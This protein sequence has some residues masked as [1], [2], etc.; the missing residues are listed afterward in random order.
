MAEYC[1]GC[2]MPYASPEVFDRPID[3]GKYGHKVDVYSFGVL[4]MELLFDSL[5]ISMRRSDDNHRKLRKALEDRTYT[6]FILANVERLYYYFNR[7]VA[8]V[9]CYVAL[10]CLDPDP[11]Q[12]PCIDWVLVILRRMHGYIH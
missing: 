4:M 8:E 7:P 2:T 5:P 3:Y 1:P 12:R 9:L 10:R 6:Q 11:L